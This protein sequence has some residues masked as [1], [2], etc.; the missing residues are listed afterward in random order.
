MSETEI[1]FARQ[2]LIWN[3]SFYFFIGI[4]IICI[5]SFV[6]DWLIGKYYERKGK[7]KCVK[8]KNEQ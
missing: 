2:N 8:K 6:I 5:V 3:I 4:A 7:K 1:Y